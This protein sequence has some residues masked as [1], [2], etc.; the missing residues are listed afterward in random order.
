MAN[1]TKT[2]S[3]DENGT[4]T[5]V[6]TKTKTDKFGNTIVTTKERYNP[7]FAKSGFSKFTKTKQI[8]NPYG[9]SIEKSKSSSSGTPRIDA[10]LNGYS[11]VDKKA[12]KAVKYGA[13]Q[14]SKGGKVSKKTAS[15]KFACG[16][17]MSK[18]K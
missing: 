14:L 15:R 8:T 7:G 12:Y 2:V 9:V 17:K 13:K 4:K 16:G 3:R 11:P 10:M 1:R 5:R 6:K 18:K